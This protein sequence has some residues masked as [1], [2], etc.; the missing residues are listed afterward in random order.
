ML[1]AATSPYIA[2]KRSIYIEYIKEEAITATVNEISWDLKYVG[3][4]FL[5]SQVNVYSFLVVMTFKQKTLN[6]QFLK[7]YPRKKNTVKVPS[8]R[9]L[10]KQNH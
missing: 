8:K 7:T 9:G 4:H 6:H 2:T 3:A 1:W 10:E 5:L